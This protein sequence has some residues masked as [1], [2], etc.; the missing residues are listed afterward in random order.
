MPQVGEVLTPLSGDILL[1][2]ESWGG[3]FCKQLFWPHTKAPS[4]ILRVWLK[5]G[6]QWPGRELGRAARGGVS[7]LTM[8][9]WLGREARLSHLLRLVR[10]EKFEALPKKVHMSDGLTQVVSSILQFWSQIRDLKSAWV[11]FQIFVK[12]LDK[13]TPVVPVGCLEVYCI[14]LLPMISSEFFL[15]MWKVN[16]TYSNLC[17]DKT[18]IACWE[19]LFSF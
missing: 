13:S 12:S 7:S 8:G 2:E 16:W 1:S 9:K 6:S 18:F 11:P 10:S 4:C 15:R 17:G 19:P 3:C 5:G 14:V